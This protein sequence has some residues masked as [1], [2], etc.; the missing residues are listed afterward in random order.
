MSRDSVNSYI[1]LKAAL[2]KA[3]SLPL[4]KRL[5]QFCNAPPLGDCSP[6]QLLY[7]LKN[8]LGTIDPQ[9]ETL[10]LKMIIWFL[11]TEFMNRLPSNI[12]FILAAFPFKSVEKQAPIADSLMQN[13]K[14]LNSFG[15]NSTDNVF[16]LC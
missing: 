13:D 1:T 15:V 12:Q 14:L 6:T 4:H 7:D 2:I 10:T 9:D 11:Q 5:T 8:I 3:Y 16:L